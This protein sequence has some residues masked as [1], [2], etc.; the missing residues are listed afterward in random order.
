MSPYRAWPFLANPHHADLTAASAVVLHGLIALFVVGPFLL[1][2]RRRV[3]YS[4]IAFLAGV[5]VDLDHVV[6]AGSANPSAME[7]LGFRPETHTIVLALFAAV[8]VVIVLRNAVMAWCT[9]AVIASHVVFDAAGGGDRWL[10]PLSQ[11]AALPWLACPVA[12][13]ALL[14]TSTVIALRTHSATDQTVTA[15]RGPSRRASTRGSEWSWSA[16]QAIHHQ[17]RGRVTGRTGVRTATERPA[18]D[19]PE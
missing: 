19:Q 13:L 11:S 8:V 2:A 7:H 1:L 16:G 17:Q 4:V 6:A 10:Y 9:F 12:I 14:A 18:V 3:L 15:R 5:S